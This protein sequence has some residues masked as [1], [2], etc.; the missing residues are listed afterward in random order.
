[1]QNYKKQELFLYTTYYSEFDDKRR[2][3]LETALVKNAALPQITKLHILN[4]GGDLSFL[5]SDKIEITQIKQRPSYSDFFELINKRA[6]DSDIS[7]IANT[8]ISFDKNIGVLLYLP[9]EN[10]C[11]ALSRWNIEGPGRFVVYNHCESQDAWIFKGK[12]RNV[13][14]NFHIG[15]PRCDN[16]ILYELRAA[17]Y[18]VLNPAFSIRSYHHHTGYRPPYSEQ[19]LSHFVD[20]PYDYLYPHNFYPL[21]QTC[22]F[23]LRHKEKL[24]PYRYDIKKINFLLLYRILRH[25]IEFVFRIKIKPIGY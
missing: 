5:K 17:G 18:R 14:S 19:N 20:P 22:W 3:E 12:I 21:F 9:L 25:S 11:I 7:I 1:M 13:T 23:N 2:I 10:N 16:R 6:G 8:D 15:V 24:M 4:E